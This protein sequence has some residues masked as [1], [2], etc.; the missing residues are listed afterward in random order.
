MTDVPVDQETELPTCNCKWL[1]CA[2]AWFGRLLL[3]I[4]K[5][6]CTYHF[7]PTVPEPDLMGQATVDLGKVISP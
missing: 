1:G 4:P 6:E 5:P 3:R 2:P 7:P